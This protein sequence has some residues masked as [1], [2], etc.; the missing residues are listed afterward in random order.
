M[1]IINFTAAVGVAHS[2]VRARCTVGE[3]WEKVTATSGMPPLPAGHEGEIRRKTAAVHPDVHVPQ[4][5]PAC[6]FPL[7]GGED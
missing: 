6:P 7:G 5:G 2:V 3:G 4:A 1:Q